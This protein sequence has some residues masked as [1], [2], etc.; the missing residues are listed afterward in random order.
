MGMK[1]VPEIYK[2]ELVITA[3][4]NWPI[5]NDAIKSFEFVV[6]EDTSLPRCVIRFTDLGNGRL[7]NLAGLGIGAPVSF[8]INEGD[9]TAPKY[10]MGKSVN[11]M[12][13]YKLTPLAVA[14]MH[15]VG[16]GQNDGQLELLLEHPWKIFKDFSA[17]AYAG[18]SNSEI[19]KK[20]IEGAE[21]R[22][23]DFEDIDS[24]Q[25]F[26]SD[27]DGSIPRYKCAEADLD[28]ITNKLVPY[29]TINKQPA[30]FWVDEVNCIHLDTFKNMYQ[31]EAKAVVFFG[32]EADLDDEVKMMGQTSGMLAMASK[33]I[34]KIGSDNPD[35]LI[36]VLKPNVSIDD[37]SHL[38]SYTG[39]LLP[40]IS[41]GK[42]KKGMSDKAHIPVMV[43]QMAVSDA[44]DR[45][46]YRN[47][48]MSDLQAT[49]LQKQDPFNSLFTIEIETTFCGHVVHT[50]DNVNLYIAPDKTSVPPKK[51]WMNGKWHVRGIR[52]IYEEGSL[53]N[54]LILIRPSFDI[55][56]L[57][58]SLMVLDDYYAVGMSGL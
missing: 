4:D 22:G 20:L 42:L 38:F 47:H 16:V 12:T 1:L 6:D 55:N 33:R 31:A 56:K 15:S 49:A 8:Y 48:P 30:K 10:K 37:V 25:F 57:T 13:A 41:I 9:V 7:A 26:D 44:T 3:S 18:E 46:I 40:K 35:E 36:S 27:E 23:F 54:K 43:Q 52:Y 14:K 2:P 28:F 51:S 24:E 45:Q 58:T 19:I 21:G 39:H 32:T 5:P 50:G 11:G 17:H 29:T 53:K 34:V